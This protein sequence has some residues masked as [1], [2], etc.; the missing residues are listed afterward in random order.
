[1]PTT[2]LVDRHVLTRVVLAALDA[3]DVTWCLLRGVTGG[4][5]I[6]VLI[7]AADQRRAFD[8]M[9]RHGLCRLA[10]YGRGSHAFFLGRDEE[11]GGWVE[12]D[13]VTDL[14]FGRRFEHRTRVA[15][16]CLA[17]RR[18][19]DGAWLLAPEDEFWAL[20]LHCLLD[21]GR[22]ARRHTD[23]LTQLAA[24]A[25]ADSPLARC[26]PP[27]HRWPDLLAHAR[28][29]RWAALVAAAP[30]VRAVWWRA[31]PAA[32]ARAYAG[33]SLLRLV[34]RPLQAYGRRGAAVAL[35]GPDGSGKSTVAAGIAAGFRFPV[36]GVYLGLWKDAARPGP[37]RHAGQAVRRP[38]LAWR[39]YLAGLRHRALGR[40]VVF[41]RYTYDA[42]LP[43]RGSWTW[44]KRPYLR[45]LARCC[46]APDL[47]LVLDAP[48]AV[49]HARSGEY[50]PSHLEWERAE[51]RRLAGRLSRAVRV[52]A[53]RP[54]DAVTAEAIGHIWRVYRDRSAR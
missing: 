2:A 23:R 27:W 40:L 30:D 31:T 18:R 20:L 7:A 13:L 43:P 54:V 14:T 22:F 53:D 50:D 37:M 16:A 6:D 47:V 44:L 19:V 36:R 17:R 39:G 12:F 46:P 24:D 32:V 1:M 49:A 35:I 52:D 51:Y 8:V 5:D 15:P 4:G 45:V 11:T 41:D 42:L 21:K 10:A 48:G 38:L 3:A 28:A 34:E 29:G 26:L 25:S 9:A 33:T